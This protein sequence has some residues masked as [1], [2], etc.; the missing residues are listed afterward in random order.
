M[1]TCNTT[2]CHLRNASCQTPNLVIAKSRIA[3]VISD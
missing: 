3:I 2:G 1:L